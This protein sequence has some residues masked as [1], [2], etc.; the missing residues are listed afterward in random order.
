M[1]DVNAQS[2]RNSLPPTAHPYEPRLRPF[3]SA[4]AR[5]QTFEHSISQGFLEDPDPLGSS[6]SLGP[7]E[8][9]VTPGRLNFSVTS[10]PQ[11]AVTLVP[12][13]T[14]SLSKKLLIT[15]IVV[16]AAGVIGTAVALGVILNAGMSMHSKSLSVRQ[17]NVTISKLNQTVS[18]CR[19]SLLCL[20]FV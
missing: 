17:T 18:C 20:N 5:Q 12:V 6:T 19:T 1:V 15:L 13:K 4:L 2:A 11:S 16:I 7:R 8:G 3:S 14:T 10:R 9:S